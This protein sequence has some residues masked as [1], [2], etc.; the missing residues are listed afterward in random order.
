MSPSK[1]DPDETEPAEPVD[2]EFEPAPEGGADAGPAPGRKAAKGGA[3]GLKVA[4][5]V[6]AAAAIGGGSGWLAGQILHA[7]IFGGG[8][9]DSALEGRIAA[10][11]A[12]A[13][14]VTQSDLDALQARIAAL[15]EAQDAS[16]LR[17]D[18]VEQL[19]RDVAD[20]RG[21]IE[22][23][24][25]APPE[26]NGG[27]A[28]GPDTSAALAD[29]EARMASAFDEVES[30][31][32]AAAETARNAQTAAEEA[33]S[34]A[35]QALSAA[36][37]GSD[38]ET[39]ED[40]Q[41]ASTEAVRA[42]VAALEQNQQALADRLSALETLSQRLTA[43]EQ[44]AADA[45]SVD[46]LS[47]RL[48]A[49]EASVSALE[50]AAA[51]TAGAA[52]DHRSLAARALAYAALS[53]AASG[54]D[55]FAA[56][57]AELARLWPDAPGRAELEALARTGA[58]AIEDLALS[59]PADALRAASGEA[60]TFFGVLR[61]RRD[62]A[63]GPAAAMEAALAEDDLATALEIAAGL[64]GEA[65]ASIAEWRAQAESRLTVDAALQS[66]AQVLRAE[67]EG[68]R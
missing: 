12:A 51:S 55:A 53:E 45:Q 43:L 48:A 38:A 10:L 28:A 61:I 14:A 35:Q 31:L 41:T 25:A 27:D 49:L 6:I 32:S 2:A 33:R 11:E 54:S 40:R 30:R 19:V 22:T 7:P 29:L 66:M 34:A 68:A 17:G 16:G 36:L 5:F 39:G 1:T 56:E 67:Q 3:G 13:P 18:A 21:R 24:Q 26:S 15:E 50:G 62:G 46:A 23:L 44:S 37:A 8:S 9:A 47:D 59:F 42:A 58:P 4:L 60:E 64:D 52:E 57:Y 63:A 20:L 65:A